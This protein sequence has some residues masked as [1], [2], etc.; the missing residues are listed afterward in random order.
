[1]S[2]LIKNLF[3]KPAC[4]LSWWKRGIPIPTKYLQRIEP[5]LIINFCQASD[6]VIKGFIDRDAEFL[7]STLSPYLY[8]QIAN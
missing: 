2:N 4:P 5:G 6:S 3:V 7:K 1:M 8:S